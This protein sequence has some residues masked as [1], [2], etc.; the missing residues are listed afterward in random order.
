ML[1]RCCVMTGNSKQAQWFSPPLRSV[2]AQ[3]ETAGERVVRIS[4]AWQ[5][6][7]YVY[8][9]SVYIVGA[10]LVDDFCVGCVVCALVLSTTVQ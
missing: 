9:R 4:A 8:W 6:S 10:P 7:T 3:H 5:R 2:L 1:C